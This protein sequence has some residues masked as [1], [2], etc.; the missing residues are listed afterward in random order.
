MLTKYLI[1]LSI[2]QK[3][4]GMIPYRSF[5]VTVILVTLPHCSIVM[6]NRQPFF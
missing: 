4:N 2:K 5:E 3:N 6:K 1:Q